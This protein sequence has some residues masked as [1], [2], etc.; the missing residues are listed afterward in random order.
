M[1]TMKTIL[2][3]LILSLIFMTGNAQKT[4]S[5]QALRAKEPTKT[6]EALKNENGTIYNIVVM[7]SDVEQLKPIMM[8]AETLMKEDGNHYGIFEIIVCGK[9]IGDLTDEKKIEQFKEDRENAKVSIV[10]C[11]FSLKKFDVDPD[12]LPE[13]VKVIDNGILHNLELQKKGYLSLGL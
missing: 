7:T 5:K 12:K 11:G 8:A 1:R 13:Y 6:E 9:N 3:T 10:A 4:L 2:S